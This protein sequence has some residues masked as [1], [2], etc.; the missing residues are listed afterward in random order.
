[1]GAMAISTLA[2]TKLVSEGAT[3]TVL[4][5][6]LPFIKGFTLLY[7][8]TA[9][10]W[11]P[12][13]VIIGVWRHARRRFRL[14]YDPVS[15]EAVFPV[16]MYTACTDQ[17]AG[18]LGLPFLNVVPQSLIYVALVM[19]IVTLLGMLRAAGTILRAHR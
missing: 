7:W 15:W 14:V 13:L 1:M 2:G 3:S 19:W 11:I 9:T 16:G 5:P 4:G 18:S 12:M 8:S 17:L 6:I 10:W